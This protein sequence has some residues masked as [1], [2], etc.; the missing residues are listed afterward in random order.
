MMSN[1]CIKHL[2]RAPHHE[3]TGAFSPAI[4]TKRHQLV[5]PF[6]P[7]ANPLL[8]INITASYHHNIIAF[9]DE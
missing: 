6:R 3:I 4:P 9:Y 1:E 8:I 5:Q 2:A 7:Y